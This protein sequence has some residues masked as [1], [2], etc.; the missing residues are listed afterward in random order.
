MKPAVSLLLWNS[1][2]V[3]PVPTPELRCREKNACLA[4]RGRRFT[5]ETLR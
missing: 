5:S 3:F 1:A 4:D 2:R